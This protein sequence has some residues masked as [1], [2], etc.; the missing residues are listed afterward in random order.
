MAGHFTRFLL[1]T[2]NCIS[3]KSEV[4][5][6]QEQTKNSEGQREA[7][8]DQKGSTKEVEAKKIRGESDEKAGR[9]EEAQRR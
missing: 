3:G 5:H 6:G 9:G 7:E 8:K 4:C 2:L 1:I